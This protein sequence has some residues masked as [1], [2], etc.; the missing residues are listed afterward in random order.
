MSTQTNIGCWFEIPVSNLQKAQQF[1]ASV[2]GLELDVTLMGPNEVVMLSNVPGGSGIGGHLYEGKPAQTGS[3]IH[4]I[5]PEGLDAARA[6]VE[7][8]GGSVESPDITVPVGRFFYAKDP[9]GNS[10]GV[11]NG[12]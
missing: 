4:L 9:D 8:A 10:I 3:T 12:A 1:Y 2:F 7:K 11:F 5:A 6:R